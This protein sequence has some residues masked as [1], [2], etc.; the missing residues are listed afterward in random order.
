MD[1]SFQSSFLTHKTVLIGPKAPQFYILYKA[2][3]E[4]LAIQNVTF[5][6]SVIFGLFLSMYGL[7]IEKLVKIKCSGHKNYLKKGGGHA[8]KIYLCWQKHPKFKN[9]V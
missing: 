4:L 1:Y 7:K 9:L 6:F 2:F 3:R 8:I 5:I